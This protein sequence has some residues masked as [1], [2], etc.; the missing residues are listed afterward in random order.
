MMGYVLI[1]V[2]EKIVF[3]AHPDHGGHESDE[4]VQKQT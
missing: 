3:N 4:V 2:I 1:L